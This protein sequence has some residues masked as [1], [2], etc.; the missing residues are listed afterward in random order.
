[1]YE[2]LKLVNGPRLAVAD[3][4]PTAPADVGPCVVDWTLSDEAP[5]PF[6]E[7]GPGKSVEGSPDVVAVQKA[8]QPPVQLPHNLL[9]SPQHAGER[10]GAEEKPKSHEP[11]LTPGLTV[12]QPMTV[13]FEP[14]PGHRL[15]STGLS[16]DIIAHHQPDHPVSK[17][18]G[19]LLEQMLHA[20]ADREHPIWFFAGIGPQVGA[21]TVL[22][23]LAVIAATQRQRRVVV[24]EGNLDRPGLADR[25]GLRVMAGYPEVLAGSEALEYMVLTGSL[26]NLHLLP[27][28]PPG[29]LAACPTIRVEAAAWLVAWLRER[30]DLTL[31]DGPSLDDSSRAAAWI[32]ACQAV[33][34]VA[35]DKKVT[36]Q[37]ELA[38]SV[39]K[40]GGRLRGMIHTYLDSREPAA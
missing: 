17:Q 37:K 15:A 32:H 38:R 16:P 26:P 36:G 40:M 25:L 12:S 28:H 11:A 21:T 13:A 9:A 7:V 31:I 24:V 6:I 3:M 23:N 10:N 4:K 5:A 22:L 19:L 29:K 34:A 14:W 30:Y 8:H 18:Y 35:A 27:A 33:Y 2:T 39:S 20:E 1:M